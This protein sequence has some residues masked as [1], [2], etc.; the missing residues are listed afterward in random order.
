MDLSLLS[1]FR[2]LLIQFFDQIK[3]E[4]RQ[5][6]RDLGLSR[7]HS[8]SRRLYRI[9]R[10]ITRSLQYLEAIIEIVDSRIYLLE[11]E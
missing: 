2:S 9:G 5:L 4:E 3:S 11:F 6:L 1:D 8:T 7:S 10:Q